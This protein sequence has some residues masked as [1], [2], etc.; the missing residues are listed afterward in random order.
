MK[1][2]NNI[3]RFEYIYAF[4]HA[5]VLAVALFYF[6]ASEKIVMMVLGAIIASSSSITAFYFTKHDPKKEE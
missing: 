6:R 3:I 2:I 5:L 4:I 1:N